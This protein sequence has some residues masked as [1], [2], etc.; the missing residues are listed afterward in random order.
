MIIIAKFIFQT[1]FISQYLS[2]GVWNIGGLTT[3]RNQSMSVPDSFQW[4]YIFGIYKTDVQY[5]SSRFHR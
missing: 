2:D 4:I 5:V 1:P 3:D